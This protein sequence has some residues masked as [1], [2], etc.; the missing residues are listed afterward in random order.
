MKKY[1]CLNS[2]SG[3]KSICIIGHINADPDALSSMVVLRELIKHT[4]KTHRVDLFSESPSINEN[5]LAIIDENKLY[6][7]QD[8][9]RIKNY[10]VCIILDSPNLD[11]L[12]CF[13]FLYTNAKQTINIDHHATNLSI[14]QINIIENRSSCCEIIYD[15]AKHFKYPLSTKQKGKLYAGIITDTNNFTVG[16]FSNKTF[17]ICADLTKNID[18]TAIYNA[19][20][21]NN[22]L[23]TLQLLSL[24]IN[25][26]ASFD[27]N[28]IIITHIS[29][30][31][32]KKH[33]ATH[34]DL[35]K[36]VNQIA[37]INTAKLI[38]F[39]EPRETSYYVSMRAKEGYNVAQ[40]AKTHGGG[41]HI[42]AA[43]FMSKLSLKETEQL[44]LTEFRNQLFKVKPQIKKIFR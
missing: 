5:L 4:F 16:N 37:T 13:K 30:D 26:I 38:C 15:I 35:C 9:L 23:K 18:K 21:A 41:G 20:L 44:I 34:D 6:T 32:A 36:I 25:N 27:H 17:K 1:E 10:D 29:I 43:A 24:A 14:A 12:G 28:Q 40:I 31:E 2:L 19:F 3:A 42:G 7:N 11:R 22:S 8:N 39:I 33:K